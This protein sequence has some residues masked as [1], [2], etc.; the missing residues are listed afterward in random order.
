MQL[1]NVKMKEDEN[2]E[3]K[4][5]I[6][7]DTMKTAVAFSNTRGGTIFIGVG[8]NGKVVGV[9]NVDEVSK[10]AA[11]MVADTVR[12][13]ITTSSDIRPMR[14]EGEDV[15]AINVME[16]T[17]KPYYLRDKGLRP[18]GVYIRN[19]PTS[20]PAPE[21]LILKMVRENSSHTYESAVSSYQDLTFDSTSRIFH[22]SKIDL[23]EPQMRSLGLIK[24][25]QYTNL[26]YLLSDQCKRG[27]KLAVFDDWSKD[28]FRDREEISGSVLEQAEKAYAFIERYN[29]LR[30]EIG[31]LRRVDFRAYPEPA[32]REA[33]INAIVHRDYSINGSTLV[34]IFKGSI[35]V[36][37]V[38]GL[39]RDIGYDDILLGIS[40]L[41]NPLLAGVFYRLRMIET[42]GTGIPRIM[43]AYKDNILTPKIETSTNVFKI[44]LPELETTGMDNADARAVLR[45]FNGAEFISRSDLERSLGISR[46]RANSILSEL[47][48]AGK[49]KVAGSGRNTRYKLN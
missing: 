35:S 12:P 32:I 21:S 27:I 44:T 22:E 6:T 48:S 38:G 15:V 47:V 7:K 45:L 41:R 11:Q 10:L 13:D 39:S 3:F 28:I 25:E 14:I 8:D 36:S 18:E 29:P 17:S 1:L 43:G 49:L 19:G 42:Y 24:G 16:G 31:G 9:N 2:T 34:S 30:T 20:V 46:S 4:R 23:S 37:S 33:V 5:E 40:S 26:A